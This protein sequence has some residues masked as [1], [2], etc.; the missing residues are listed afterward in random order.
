MKKR[1]VDPRID[2]LRMLPSLQK[3]SKEG[4]SYL[5]HLQISLSYP[6]MGKDLSEIA[7]M[8]GPLRVPPLGLD[9]INNCVGMIQSIDAVAKLDEA[10][11]YLRKDLKIDF[12]TSVELRDISIGD[13]PPEWHCWNP[14]GTLY[15]MASREGY[16]IPG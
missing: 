16:S 15:R 2:L 12:L 14:E 1:G 13:R 4:L 9:A 11:T 7:S 6:I 10:H 5:E 8:M 3:V